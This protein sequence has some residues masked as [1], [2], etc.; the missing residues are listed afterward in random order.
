MMMCSDALMDQEGRF[1]R[2]LGQVSQFELI[3]DGLIL[4][5]EQGKVLIRAS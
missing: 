1:L 4:K 3:D 2:A 5:S